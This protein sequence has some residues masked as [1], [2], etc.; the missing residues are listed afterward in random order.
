[1]SDMKIAFELQLKIEYVP[2]D[3]LVANKLNPKQHPDRQINA[4]TR[5]I[6]EVGFL[7]PILSDRKNQ[8]VA[9][10][11]RV[12]AARKA[13]LKTVPVVRIEHLNDHQ[14]RAAHRSTQ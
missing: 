5:S 10:H 6:N 8:I 7:T 13:G 2:I 1:M 9:G 12:I 14:L 3:T 11:A 4:L